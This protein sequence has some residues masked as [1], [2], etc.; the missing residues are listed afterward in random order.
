MEKELKPG[1]DVRGL[2][3]EVNEEGGECKTPGFNEIIALTRDPTEKVSDLNVFGKRLGPGKR[4]QKW[5]GQG[6]PRGLTSSRQRTTLPSVKRPGSRR[7]GGRSK[8]GKEP[9][10]RVVR[11]NIVRQKEQTEGVVGLHRRD[12]TGV[13]DLVPAQGRPRPLRTRRRD[14]PEYPST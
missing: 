10:G 3:T 1:F 12:D 2:V 13:E 6:G 4:V 5:S 11:Q 14:L 7:Q 9:S 8:G